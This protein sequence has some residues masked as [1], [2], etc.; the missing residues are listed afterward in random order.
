[1]L[2]GNIYAIDDTANSLLRV[3]QLTNAIT[4]VGSTGVGTGDFGDLTYD[5]NHNVMYW[6]PGRGNNNLYTINVST[7]AATLVGS[8]GINGMFALAYDTANDTL[9]AESQSTQNLYSLNTLTG[10]ATLIGSS[11]ITVVGGFTYRPDNNTL[12]LMQSGGGALYTIN[13]S[14]GAATLFSAGSGFVDDGGIAWDPELNLFWV[15][16][17]GPRD[18]LQYNAAFSSRSQVAV[19]GNTL[20]GIAFVPGGGTNVPE[21]GTL[22]LLACGG[23]TLGLLRLRLKRSVS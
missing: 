5:A 6:V 8:H 1:M 15:N 3:D 2:A 20:D 21:P 14:T 11:G 12:Y 4:L 13:T 16:E 10:A 7:G 23:L 18:I 17:F 22:G 19:H 9:Y